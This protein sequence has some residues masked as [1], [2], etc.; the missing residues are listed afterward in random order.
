MT[1][2]TARLYQSSGITTA[3]ISRLGPRYPILVGARNADVSYGSQNEIYRG[4]GRALSEWVTQARLQDSMGAYATTNRQSASSAMADHLGLKQKHHDTP[5]TALGFAR[6]SVGRD[7]F[8]RYAS[9]YLARAAIT[10]ITTKHL[11]ARVPDDRRTDL[12]IIEELADQAWPRFLA[13]SGLDER[14]VEANAVVDAIRPDNRRYVASEWI[15]KALARLRKGAARPEGIPALQWQYRVEQYLR[16]EGP[17]LR[18]QLRTRRLAQAREWVDTIQGS[19]VEHA[20]ES[21]A[22]HGGPVCPEVAR[23]ARGGGREPPSTGCPRSATRR[24]R[25]AVALGEDIR[26]AFSASGDVAPASPDLEKGRQDAAKSIGF[27][28]EADLLTTGGAAACATSSSS[29]CSP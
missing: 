23:K 22:T 21:V 25:R 16:E 3:S 11:D 12:Q 13:G 28:A 24:C 1:E 20:L 29:C 19:L 17:A 18:E 27:E 15:E 26:A 5:F 14:G 10:R 7:L 2:S 4:M 6:L 8:E 9:Q